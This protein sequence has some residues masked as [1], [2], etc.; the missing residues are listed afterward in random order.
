MKLDKKLHLIAGALASF[1]GILFGLIAEEPLWLVLVTGVLFSFAA[2]G[3][4]E[5]YDEVTGKGTPETADLLYTLAGGVFTS[6][7]VFVVH[8]IYS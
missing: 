5:L 4:K 8:V 1:V 2:G 7:V 6:L 3:A